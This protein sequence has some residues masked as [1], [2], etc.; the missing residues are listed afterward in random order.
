MHRSEAL[1]STSPSFACKFAE[2]E[3]APDCDLTDVIISAAIYRYLGQI[4]L[5]ARHRLALL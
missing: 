5:A 3:P 1:N 4:L 2:T